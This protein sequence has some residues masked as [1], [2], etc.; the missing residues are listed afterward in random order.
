MAKKGKKGKKVGKVILKV[1]LS[2]VI[3]IVLCTCGFM[4]TTAVGLSAN[5]KLI[6]SENTVVK[7]DTLTPTLDENGYWTF[8]TDEEFVILQLTDVHLG[9]GALSIQKDSWAIQAVADL[10]NEVQP[11]LV[12]VTGDVAYP[13]P[14]QSG[15]LNNLNA[16]EL[17]GELME[18]LGV[19]WAFT[20]GNH[21]TELYS[22]YD[23][24]EIAEYYM[25]EEINYAL[26]SEAHCL[27]QTGPEEVDGYSNYIINVKNT[28]NIITQSLFLFDSHSYADGDYFGIEWK[29][30]NI[31][32]NQ[33]EWYS[34]Q[35]MALD[36]QNK[37]IDSSCEMFKSL[38]FFHIPLT[39]YLDAWT[40]YIDNGEEDTENVQYK[41]GVAGE[42]GNV[43]YCGVDRDE[44]FT[45]MLELQ[46]TQGIFVG[47]DH[48]NNFSVEYKGIRLTYGM[49]IDYLAYSGIASKT[50]QRGG[51]V[52]TVQTDG[53]FDCYGLRLVDKEII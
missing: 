38:A 16:T 34:E 3:I 20:F 15:T 32:E 10:V 39:E 36:A 17:F 29:Y 41:Y 26:N 12:V 24:E 35:I 51:T 47:H 53:S 30:D 14:Y 5:S 13:V 9:G 46:S 27:F 43:V 25:S 45:T 52:I 42:S 37:A 22:Y 11:D 21:D 19:Y 31:H 44:L 33:I 23:R 4:I 2:I 6:E 7:E 28:S 18:Q 40:E 49:S 8:T 1:F 50:A 48:L